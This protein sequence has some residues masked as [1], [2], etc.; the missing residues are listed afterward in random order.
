MGRYSRAAAVGR[1][2]PNI[3]GGLSV[4]PFITPPAGIYI[5]F[6]SPLAFK[7]DILIMQHR[8]FPPPAAYRPAIHHR[9]RHAIQPL[10]A[11]S[12]RG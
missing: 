4:M 9:R 10:R 11:M 12:S 8:Y 5:S 2:L 7:E 3:I 1:L 6:V